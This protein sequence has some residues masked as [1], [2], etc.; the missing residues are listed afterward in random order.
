MKTPAKLLLV[1]GLLLAALAGA[2]VAR[3]TLPGGGSSAAT[4]LQYGTALPDPQPL[5]DFSLVSQNGEAIDAGALR[6]QWS[7]VFFGF[8]HCPGVCPA[9]LALLGDVQKRIGPGAPR[10][11]LVSV[12]PERDT[13][14]AMQDYLARFDAGHLGITGSPQAIESFTA[15]MGVAHRKMPMDGGDY[16]VDHTAAVFVVDGAGRRVAI[17][18]PPLDAAQIASD[19]QRLMGG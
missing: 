5:P 6:G 8:T 9:T 3:G 4:Q 2:W 10:V 16:M 11:V 1:A 12:D 14:A 19:V 7:F 13:P 15:A 17:F 18:S